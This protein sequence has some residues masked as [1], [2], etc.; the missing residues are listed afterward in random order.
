MTMKSRAG[1]LGVALAALS[2][3]APLSADFL[4]FTT[5]GLPG[6]PGAMIGRDVN[7]DGQ[8]D[9]LVLHPDSGQLSIIRSDG[10]GGFLAPTVFS[11][12]NQPSA[13]V[14]RHIEI[15]AQFDL[16]VSHSKSGVEF[17]QIE[18][19]GEALIL[20]GG[21][22]G[23]PIAGN[24]AE[25]IMLMPTPGGRFAPRGNAGVIAANPGT[26]QVVSRVGDGQGGFQGSD[27]QWTD[28]IQ[29][30]ATASGD[31]NGD[32]NEDLVVGN[33][34]GASLSILLYESEIQFGGVVWVQ[35]DG[36]PAAIE[37]GAAPSALAVTDVDRNGTKDIIV[38]TKSPSRLMIWSG[39][40]DGSFTQHQVVELSAEPFGLA[41]TD[42]EGDG[43]QD[44]I[45]GLEVGVSPVPLATFEVLDALPPSAH[46]YARGVSSDG[47][48]VVG[49]SGEA[50]RHSDETGLEGLG[51]LMGSTGHSAGL[52]VS[53]DGET[54]VGY[55]SVPGSPFPGLGAF[56]WTP[57]QGMQSLGD[58]GRGPSNSYANDVSMNGSV[59]GYVTPLNQAPVRWSQNGDMT[60][61]DGPS[62]RDPVGEATA[63]SADGGVI[64]G[65][66]QGPSHTLAFRWTESS[67]LV[68]LPPFE[69]GTTSFA[70]DVSADGLVVIGRCEDPD[71]YV[72]TFRWTERGGSEKLS[73]SPL[74]SWSYARAVSG[75]GSVIV[76]TIY[77]PTG[78]VPAIW[79]PATGW[80]SVS[81]CLE[82]LGAD[83]QGW[84][85]WEVT[86]VSTDG[87][88]LVGNASLGGV[89]RGWKASIPSDLGAALRGTLS[90]LRNLGEGTLG[91]PADVAIGLAPLSLTATDVDGD[92][93]DDLAVADSVAKSVS[94][95]LNHPWTDITGDGLVNGADIAALLGG[96]GSCDPCARCPA[97]LNGDCAVNGAD[98][99]ALLGAW[100]P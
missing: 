4:P 91:P 59:V 63:L 17:F 23:G 97:D 21:F 48:W 71:G 69:G 52:A 98:I 30:V 1:R 89:N 5:L 10:A 41:V 7:G 73:V 53:S 47:V 60:L 8:A 62:A 81:S 36:A 54:V 39:N 87:R 33:G 57:T 61:L 44:V 55:S 24:G 9:L 86:D 27:T 80:L 64:V 77:L 78:A 72:Q 35:G 18:S 16:A 26:N 11:V 14:S 25:S 85:L 40:G 37:L 93:R 28:G 19:S 56:K 3:A 88:T 100:S 13:L 22:S 82:T 49:H 6:T 90:I 70:A 68:A 99:T 45:V 34:G 46:G 31:F 43:D 79:T 58:L 92:G 2:C 65:S 20:L 42:V 12:G 76:G 75:D 74:P 50:F 84:Q 38:T 15:E 66:F 94:V 29:P 95:L 67:G 83:L 96:W 32:G 51:T